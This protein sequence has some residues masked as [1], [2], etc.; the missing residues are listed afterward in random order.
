MAHRTILGFAP[1]LAIALLATMAPISLT[2]QQ[3]GTKTDSA[4]KSPGRAPQGSQVAGTRVMLNPQLL[5]PK[6]S[7]EPVYP[8]THLT[9]GTVNK[10][11]QYAPRLKGPSGTGSS[12]GQ[13]TPTTSLPPGAKLIPGVATP[14]KGDSLKPVVGGSFNQPQNKTP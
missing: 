14:P 11:D 5:P 7:P 2:A 12:G 9:N 13:T 4:G 3:S 6:P 1:A 8:T 10:V